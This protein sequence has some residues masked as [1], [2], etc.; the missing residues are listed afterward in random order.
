MIAPSHEQLEL[1]MKSIFQPF[2]LLFVLFSSS[3]LHVENNSFFGADR[4]ERLPGN[5][6]YYGLT[7]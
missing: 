2:Y 7:S 1:V 6:R 3:L 5:R 4:M